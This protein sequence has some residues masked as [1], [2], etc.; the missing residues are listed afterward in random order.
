MG[1]SDGGSSG[2]AGALYRAQ[3]L[4]RFPQLVFRLTE[5]EPHQIPPQFGAAEET[6][7]RHGCDAGLAGEPAGELV[8]R[9]VGE[10]REIGED[11]VGALG[12][13]T[14]EAGGEQRLVQQVAPHTVL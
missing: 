1:R 14:A 10:P 3:P 5:R 12:W 9:P 13:H 8:V 6:R 2:S 4:P 11:V 7:T